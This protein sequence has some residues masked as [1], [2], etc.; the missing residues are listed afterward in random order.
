M[1]VEFICMFKNV[2]LEQQDEFMYGEGG[3]VI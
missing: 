2:H 1:F 3:E